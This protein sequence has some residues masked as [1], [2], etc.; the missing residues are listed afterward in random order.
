MGSPVTHAT[1]MLGAVLAP[2][3]L[4][5]NIHL[6]DRWDP[7]RVLDDHARGRR[8][9]RHRRVG[10][11]REPARP[12]RASPP[13]TPA[14][15]GAS[16]SAARRCRVALAER[17]AAHGIAIMRGVRLDRAPVGHAAA[18]FDDP[19]DKRHAH[20]RPTDAGRRDPAPRRRRRAVAAGDAGRDLVA[21][22]RPVRRLHRPGAD[23]E[24]R[25]TTT[26]GTAPA[27]WASSTPTASSRSPTGSTT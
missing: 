10:V 2:M 26:A 7:D 15:S 16:V 9:R 14:A 8:R 18:T 24:A 13:S 19:A 5:E 20:R 12:S 22:S 21:R 6:I 17:A 27:T 23:R 3:A 1:G 11:P 4:G 25:S